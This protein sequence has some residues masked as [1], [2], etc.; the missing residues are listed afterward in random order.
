MSGRAEAKALRPEILLGV[1]YEETEGGFRS[2]SESEIPKMASVTWL[3]RLAR[4]S[5]PHQEILAAER[6]RR[7][8]ATKAEEVALSAGKE[9]HEEGEK[10]KREIVR[11]EEAGR[12]RLEEARKYSAHLA[13]KLLFEQ[14][15]AEAWK[16]TA[17]AWREAAEVAGSP[18]TW[19][20]LDKRAH[21][22]ARQ[23][24]EKAERSE[25]LQAVPESPTD[26]LARSQGGRSK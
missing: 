13:Q 15:R 8:W 14:A 2:P 22:E 6:Q 25:R 16:A 26:D 1:Y 7:L 9:A 3:S 24:E 20:P 11:E 17:R 18:H 19:G 23:R 5:A 21:H 12:H 4:H 10:L